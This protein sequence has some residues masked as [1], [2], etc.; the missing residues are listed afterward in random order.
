MLV[1]HR[2]PLRRERDRHPQLFA[3]GGVVE[4]RR[5][6]ADDVVGPLVERDLTADHG[7][8]AG[9]AIAPQPVAE[10]DDLLAPGPVFLG[11]ED[12]AAFRR[13]VEDAEEAG[14]HTRADDA[15]GIAVAGH[16]EA[17]ELHRRRRRECLHRLDAVDEVAGRDAAAVAP[18][19]LVQRDDSLRRRERQ[20]L[21]HDRLDGAEDRGSRADAES[22]RDDSGEREPG[23]AKQ[24]PDGEGDVLPQFGHVLGPSHLVVPLLS[25]RPAP[26]VDP[27]DVA[28]A[29]DRFLARCVRAHPALDELADA[30]LDVEG[31][32]GVDLVVDARPPEPRAQ[33]LAEGHDEGRST[34]ETPAENLAHSA[35]SAASWRRPLAV[36][37]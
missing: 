2:A 4:A 10:N 16:V 7:R 5:H 30:H 9:E 25:E 1:V 33:P 20:R 19:I 12:A 6:H 13:H 22:E 37:R 23:A 21:Q 29:P 34:L 31:E 28:E 17:R 26:G 11:R 32:L 3:V 35:V 27:I 14:G 36:T 18:Q 15:L 24:L 8:I